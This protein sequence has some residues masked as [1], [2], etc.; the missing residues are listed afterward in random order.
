MTRS[1]MILMLLCVTATGCVTRVETVPMCPIS[2]TLSI[3]PTD[4]GYTVTRTDMQALL[5]YVTD[6]EI[7]A[8]CE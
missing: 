8:G 5:H 3:E 7:A 2:P 6:L 4:N 1:M